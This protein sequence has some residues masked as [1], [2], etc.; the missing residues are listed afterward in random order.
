LAICLLRFYCASVVS[1]GFIANLRVRVEHGAAASQRED[2]YEVVE[3]EHHLYEL[4]LPICG[5]LSLEICSPLSLEQSPLQFDHPELHL[6]QHGHVLPEQ[7][8]LSR[9]CQKL[10]PPHHA[11][12]HAPLH[13][14]R[15]E[16]L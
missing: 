5:L 7:R 12:L 16:L 3:V 1:L 4:H 2:L 6:P 11:A 8:Y 13:E 14:L 10:Q 9:L 15:V